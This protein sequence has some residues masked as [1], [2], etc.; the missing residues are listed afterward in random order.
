MMM[1]VV[2][3]L[4]QGCRVPQAKQSELP[5]LRQNKFAST[6]IHFGNY[7]G[8]AQSSSSVEVGIC[9]KRGCAPIGSE[10]IITSL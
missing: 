10:N 4:G 2:V 6:F 8:W 1:I 5:D 9:S 7:V 3:S